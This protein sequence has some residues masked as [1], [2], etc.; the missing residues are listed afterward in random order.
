M[1]TA[2][3]GMQDAVVVTSADAVLVCPRDRA[4]DVK[5]IVDALKARGRKE[6]T[7]HRRMYRP[8]GFYEGLIQGERF[9]VKRIQVTP[10]AKLSL[11]KHFHRAEHWVVVKGT[12]IVTRD[13]ETLMVRE[14]ESVYLPLGCVHR[15]ENPGKIPLELIEVQVGSYTGEDDI[16]RIEDTYGR[17]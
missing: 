15:M 3:L 17:A 13:H 10:G 5:A 4:Q 2:V 11:Q 6:G 1:L 7:E 14:T 12:A 8:W 9:Q 16:V